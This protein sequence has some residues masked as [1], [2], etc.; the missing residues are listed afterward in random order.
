SSF[1]FHQAAEIGLSPSQFL[2]Y[3]LRISIQERLWQAKE[4]PPYS[5]LL[6]RLDQALENLKKE[7]RQKKRIAVIL[8]GYSYER[9]IS[10]ESGR[11]IFEKLSSSDK[12]EPIP[13]F[14]SGGP[15]GH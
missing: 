2:T 14:L 10:V 11:N 7:A 15:E 5:A 9:H 3:I 6:P 4:R 8:G 12:Y 1:F 13:V